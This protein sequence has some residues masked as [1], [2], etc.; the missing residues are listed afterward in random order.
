[1]SVERSSALS[2]GRIDAGTWAQATIQPLEPRSQVLWHVQ[3]EVVSVRSS[4]KASSKFCCIRP[5]DFI[6]ARQDALLSTYHAPPRLRRCRCSAVVL[7]GGEEHSP[8][9]YMTVMGGLQASLP[10]DDE[11]AFC[12]GL[13]RLCRNRAAQVANL[14]GAKI[15]VSTVFHLSRRIR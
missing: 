6:K 1:M 14:S 15:S 2:S 7:C 12:H 4:A 3:L 9:V 13:H 10:H 11:A 5:A 8:A